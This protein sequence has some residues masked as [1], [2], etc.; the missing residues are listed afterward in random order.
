[1]SWVLWD[2]ANECRGYIKGTSLEKARTVIT[3]DFNALLI[4]H[5][6]STQSYMALVES[7]LQLGDVFETRNSPTGSP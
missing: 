4:Y 6:M 3:F 2:K 1:M 5:L 7:I